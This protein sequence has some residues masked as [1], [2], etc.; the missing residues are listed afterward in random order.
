[1]NI[2]IVRVGVGI[3]LGAGVGAQKLEKVE[4][5]RRYFIRAISD[6]ETSSVGV[7]DVI[8]HRVNF[9]LMIVQ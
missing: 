7:R 2:Q 9:D 5:K 3:I 1:M 4:K 6:L 8:R